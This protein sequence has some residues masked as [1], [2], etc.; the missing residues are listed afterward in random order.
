MKQVRLEDCGFSDTHYMLSHHLTSSFQSRRG[1]PGPRKT[2]IVC[3]YDA[4]MLIYVPKGTVHCV[5][6]WSI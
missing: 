6:I 2:A 3:S 4:K 1:T 5:C